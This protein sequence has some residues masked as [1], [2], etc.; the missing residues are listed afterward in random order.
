MNLFSSVGRNLAVGFVLTLAV[1]VNSPVAAQLAGL[2]GDGWH[3]WQVEAVPNSPEICCFRWSQGIASRRACNLDAGHGG[4]SSSSDNPPGSGEIQV[5]ALLDGDEIKDLRALSA[6][7]PVVAD[8]QITDLGPVATATSVSWLAAQIEPEGDLAA[9]AIA[10]VA[11]HAG[12]EAAGVL[13]RTA[14]AHDDD[15][16]E[17]AIF[18]MAQVRVAEMAD[19]IKQFIFEDDDPDIRE[20]AAFSY[21]QS[22]AGDVADVLIRQGRRDRDPEVRSAA[23]FWLAQSEAEEAEQEIRRAMREDDDEDVRED[24]V[25]A[26]SQ[27]PDERAVN[28]LGAII[29]DQGLDHEMREEALFWLAQS[30]SDEAFE[31]ID[32][33]LK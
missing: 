24:A 2:S 18:W 11:V 10:G 19:Q 20:H 6:S 33:I 13:L 17:D 23:W 15:N 8:G 21:S 12:A 30:E 1:F 31:Y 3:T 27:L 7:C 28:A 5:Y 25:F 16:R 9:E 32:D 29:E 26:L 14:Q 22:D 4:Y